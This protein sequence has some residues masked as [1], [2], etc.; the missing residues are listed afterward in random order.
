MD[1]RGHGEPGRDQRAPDAG[2]LPGAGRLLTD[3]AARRCPAAACRADIEGDT[4][5]SVSEIAA[6][7]GF[8]SASR[9][10]AA[11]RR[12]YGHPPSLARRT[13]RFEP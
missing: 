3:R 1:R 9:F 12:R 4:G 6:R 2:G 10:A 11:Y 13:G 7:W 8:S 5:L